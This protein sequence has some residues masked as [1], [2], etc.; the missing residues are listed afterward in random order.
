MHLSQQAPKL[1][2]YFPVVTD[3]DGREIWMQGMAA[4]AYTLVS[5]AHVW[6]GSGRTL[7]QNA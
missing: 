7:W 6:Q 2:L 4:L 1:A 3:G 5:C